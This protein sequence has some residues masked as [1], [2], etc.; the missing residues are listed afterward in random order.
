M[1]IHRSLENQ[2]LETIC[3]FPQSIEELFFVSPKFKYPLT[4]EQILELLKDRYEPTVVVDKSKNEVVAYANIYGLDSTECSCWL[5]NVIVSHEY[6]GKGVA[7]YLL[8]N[9]LDKAKH[10]LGMKKIQLSCHNTNSRGMAFYYKY[11]FKPVDIR[12]TTLEENKIITIQMNKD[13]F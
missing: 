4:P 11:G 10:K 5:G 13:L 7:K 8:D 1:Y 3:N 6:R 12:I 9:I 2:D